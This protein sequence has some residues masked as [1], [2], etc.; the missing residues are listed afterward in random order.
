MSRLVILCGKVNLGNK[1]SR[2]ESESEQ[3]VKS[4]GI[5]AKLGDLPLA[6][7]NFG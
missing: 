5:D 7:V 2:S 3:G 4:H 6:R 1:R